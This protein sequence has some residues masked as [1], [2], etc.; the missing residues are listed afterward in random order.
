[1]VERPCHAVSLGEKPNQ[2]PGT[3]GGGWRRNDRKVRHVKQGDL[4]GQDGVHVPDSPWEPTGKKSRRSGVR[5]SI[6]V[7][8]P[9][10]SGGAKG[11][12]KVDDDRDPTPTNNPGQCSSGLSPGTQSRHT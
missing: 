4:N 5:A 8:K 1:M 7:M 11:R 3:T 10:N 2:T 12:R 9:G 6:V